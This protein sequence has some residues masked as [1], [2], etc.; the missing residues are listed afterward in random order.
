MV[1][2][3]EPA[4]AIMANNTATNLI[5]CNIVS[6]VVKYCFVECFFA[7][8]TNGYSASPSDDGVLS[9]KKKEYERV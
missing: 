8:K 7:K 3:H 6:I 1:L 9:H 5:F 2:L 4:N